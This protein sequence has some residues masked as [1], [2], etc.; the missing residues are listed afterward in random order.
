MNVMRNFFRN[1]V[2]S[3]NR[4]IP[5]PARSLDVSVCHFFFWDYLKSRVFQPPFLHNIRE[6]KQWIR[7]E[8]AQIPVALPCSVISDLRTRVTRVYEPKWR[9]S[10]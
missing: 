8:V 10:L 1:H 6:L 7:E 4:D 2:I 9:S 3:K 5:W